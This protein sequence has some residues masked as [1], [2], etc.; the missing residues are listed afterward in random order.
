M[1]DHV[2][3]GPPDREAALARELLGRF[4]ARVEPRSLP[5]LNEG[6][7]PDWQVRALASLLVLGHVAGAGGPCPDG[8]PRFAATEAGRAALAAGYTPVRKAG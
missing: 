4:A 3:P 2:R 6:L 5:E 1:P 7:T 8:C